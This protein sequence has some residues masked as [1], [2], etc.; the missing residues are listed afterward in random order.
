M[1]SVPQGQEGSGSQCLQSQ[2]HSSCQRQ[3]LSVLQSLKY[4]AD[5]RL[6]SVLSYVQE[7][8]QRCVSFHPR[9][10]RA[11]RR[12]SKAQTRNDELH[13]SQGLGVGPRVRCGGENGALCALLCIHGD[14][15]IRGICYNQLSSLT[16]LCSRRICC[17]TTILTPTRQEH[18]SHQKQ[19]LFSLA[20]PHASPYICSMEV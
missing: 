19:K 10:C 14:C 5:D 15:Y 8:C 6:S 16:I 4:V 20:D 18:F 1:A 12:G 2:K 13:P 17:Y 7:S 11:A 9:V 3:G